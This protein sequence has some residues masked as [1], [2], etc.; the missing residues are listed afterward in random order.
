MHK[1]YKTEGIILRR[2]NIGEADRLIT[3][4]SK[5]SGKMTVV[6]KGVRRITSRRSAH[7]EL[8]N[9]CSFFL[10]RGKTMD[11]VADVQHINTFPILRK[12]FALVGHSYLIVELLD[13]FLPHHEE[14]YAIY[15]HTLELLTVL[16]TTAPHESDAATLLYAYKL[17]LLQQLGFTTQENN[18][19]RL[20][21][22]SFIE[23]IIE[24]RLRSPAIFA[25]VVQ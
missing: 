7:L 13:R 24:R 18:H 1:T 15:H 5:H 3:I 12:N 21:I 6:A 19:D 14:N 4:F 10:T 2:A 22:D 11:Y 8:F 25:H 23:S 16:D 17:F 9:H 20:S